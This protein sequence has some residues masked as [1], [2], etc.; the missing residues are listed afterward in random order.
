MEARVK[1]G[2][3]G[4]GTQHSVHQEGTRYTSNLS[5][6]CKIKSLF[7]WEKISQMMARTGVVLPALT[8]PCPFCMAKMLLRR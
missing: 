7:Y 6:L 3:Q 5:S 1:G 4:R 8:R 2:F